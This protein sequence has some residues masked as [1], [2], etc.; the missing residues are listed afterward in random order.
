MGTTKMNTI[1]IENNKIKIPSKD[2]IDINNNTVNIT[3]NKNIVLE[4]CDGLIDELK[5]NIYP[6]VK[7]E[8]F[9]FSK[10]LNLNSVTVFN[11]FKNAN[12]KITKFYNNSKTKEKT[13]L[14]L[15]EE[16]ANVDYHFSSICKQEE[17]NHIIINHNA[18]NTISTVIN[19]SITIDKASSNFI[20]DSYLP[21][22]SKNSLISQNTKIITLGDNYSTIKPNMYIEEN[23]VVATHGSVIGKFSQ[24]ELFYLASRGLDYTASIN[25]LAKGFL[26]GN[27]NINIR[28]LEKILNEVNKYWR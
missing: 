16:K 14:N 25:L 11:I 17:N 15:Q 13:I 5:F 24:E 28:L 3:K 1:V 10:E 8:M 27:I 12:L 9:I 4:Y 22:G 6:N 18:K 19:K 26:I 21:K 23:D 2:G 7:V 20:I